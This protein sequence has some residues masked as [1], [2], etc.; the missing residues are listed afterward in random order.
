MKCRIAQTAQFINSAA[1]LTVNSRV[2]DIGYFSVYGR[3]LPELQ[4]ARQE[5]KRS[6]DATMIAHQVRKANDISGGYRLVWFMHRRMKY[7]CFGPRE[8]V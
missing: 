5:G 4:D 2:S 6:S 8:K 7:E 1:C 3:E